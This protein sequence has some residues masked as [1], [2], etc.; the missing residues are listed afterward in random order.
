VQEA[1]EA[2]LHPGIQPGVAPLAD[3]R[4]K[5][6]RKLPKGF[7]KLAAVERLAQP[8]NPATKQ[9]DVNFFSNAEYLCGYEEQQI[10][11]GPGA[12]TVVLSSVQSAAWSAEYPS[13]L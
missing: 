8:V 12:A 5:D 3:G 1:G 4:A 7:N 13:H 10:N 11:V 2:T 9:P 6:N